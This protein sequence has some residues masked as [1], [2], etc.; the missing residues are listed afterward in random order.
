LAGLGVLA[1]HDEK[2]TITTSTT[3]RFIRGFSDYSKLK[4]ALV[5]VM[6]AVN[7]WKA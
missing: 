7:L 1:I 6:S 3:E 5:V 2:S 4:L